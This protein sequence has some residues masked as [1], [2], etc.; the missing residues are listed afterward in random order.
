VSDDL[1]IAF[2]NLENS[3]GASAVMTC[4]ILR[5]LTLDL[6]RRIRGFA[7]RGVVVVDLV[8]SPYSETRHQ[9]K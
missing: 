3:I 4:I 7:R 1:K 8:R 2:D 5:F 6:L 9:A